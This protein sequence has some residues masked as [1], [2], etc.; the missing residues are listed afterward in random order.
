MG[1][2][3]FLRYLIPFLFL[4]FIS[5]VLIASIL[6]KSRYAEIEAGDIVKRC[7]IDTF[8]VTESPS[9]IEYGKRYHYST[10]CDEFVITKR[11]DLYDIGDTITFIYKKR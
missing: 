1:N 11:Y 4:F 3:S 10:D 6:N 5:F 8:Y 7:V 9:T 2:Q